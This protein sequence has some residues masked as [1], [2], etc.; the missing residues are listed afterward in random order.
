MRKLAMFFFFCSLVRLATGNNLSSEFSGPTLV[1]KL[2][3]SN[4]D[5]ATR[6]VTKV[7]VRSRAHGNFGCLTDSTTLIPLAD[8]PISF[9]VEHAE[10]L[11]R[12]EPIIEMQAGSSAQFTVSLYPH[13]TGA[14]GPWSSEVS[15]IVEFDDGS[16]LETPAQTIGEQHL[17]K[18]RT[19]NLQRD[20]VLQGLRHIN[21]DLRLQSVRQLGKIWL[22]RVTLEDKLRLMLQDPEQ[23]VRSEVYRQITLL[24]L[25]N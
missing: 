23:R 7:G 19:R 25:Q 12:A 22:D 16:R 20:E 18:R 4:P 24:N 8:Y 11:V 5:T 15:V 1:F 10:T 3:V 21:A 14:C 17:A 9:S 6:H 2:T 13:A